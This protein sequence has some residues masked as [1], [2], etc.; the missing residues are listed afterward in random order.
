[1]RRKKNDSDLI[2]D[3]AQ[4]DGFLVLL[5]QE[6]RGNQGQVLIFDSAEKALYQ[7]RAESLYDKDC[8][9]IDLFFSGDIYDGPVHGSICENRGFFSGINIQ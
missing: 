6:I 7:K 4:L 5:R 2:L 8:P 1:M 9:R 3:I